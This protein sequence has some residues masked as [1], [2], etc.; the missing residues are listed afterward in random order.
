MGQKNASATGVHVFEKPSLSQEV[1][2]AHYRQPYIHRPAPPRPQPYIHRPAPPRPQQ[3]N[4]TPVR[5]NKSYVKKRDE[6]KN[7]IAE[8]RKTCREDLIKKQERAR[9]N[10]VKATKGQKQSRITRDNQVKRSF[11]DN[12]IRTSRLK[13]I[14][15]NKKLLETQKFKNKKIEK[16]KKASNLA[17]LAVRNL[18]M[19]GSYGGRVAANNNNPSAKAK[20]TINNRGPP[21]VKSHDALLKRIGKL[22]P[23]NEKAPQASGLNIIGN[24]EFIPKYW[25]KPVQ[26]NGRRVY[27]RSDLF[28]PK[29]MTDWKVKGK[30][31]KGSNV[32]RM[33]SGRAPLGHDGKPIELHHL[34]QNE[35]NG[36]SGTKGSLAEVDSVFHRKNTK[37]LHSPAPRN[38]NNPKETLPK[39]PSFRKN[40]DGSSN[41]QD[42]DFNKYQTEYW[43][44]RSQDF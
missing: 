27:K 7:K 25:D 12:K 2:L 28:D 40:N 24:K 34:T 18:R 35:K 1:Q 39:Y 26:V 15:Q 3:Y 23:A 19:S 33:R 43:K 20:S 4:K 11:S 8:T 44:K 29:R 42:K 31:F 21:V 5:P 37:A 10:R 41:K 16:D 6:R 30:N 32:E 13:K 9:E 14:A 38:P 22:V 36:I 17:L